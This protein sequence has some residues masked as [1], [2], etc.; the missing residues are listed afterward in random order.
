MAE[1][2]RGSRRRVR[3]PLSCWSG[4]PDSNRR[5]PA[6][7]DLSTLAIC[8]RAPHQ[9]ASYEASMMQHDGRGEAVL[10][11]LGD[12]FGDPIS[13]SAA[14]DVLGTSGESRELSRVRLGI[15]EH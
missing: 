9:S 4:R 5:R 2:R 3:N 7:E 8:F 11:P 10:M 14:R 1:N 12:R 13:E 15:A 6:W